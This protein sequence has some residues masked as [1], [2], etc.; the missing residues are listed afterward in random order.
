MSLVTP[1][2]SSLQIPLPS[3]GRGS[4]PCSVCSNALG[5]LIHDTPGFQYV[6]FAADAR[7]YVLVRASPGRHFKA[8]CLLMSPQ[9]PH[10]LLCQ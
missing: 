7:G 10:L 8:V 2:Q 6:L 9:F 3:T 4:R 5:D 1:S